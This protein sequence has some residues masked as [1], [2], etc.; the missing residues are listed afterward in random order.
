MKIKHPIGLAFLGLCLWLLFWPSEKDHLN[1][2]MAALCKKDGGVRIY[3]RVQL[4]P[5]MYNEWGSLKTPKTIKRGNEYISQ[6]A[7]IYES[8]TEKENIKNGDPFKG[9]G[10]LARHHTK[11]IRVTDKKILAEYISYSRVGGDRWF[12]G[13]PSAENCPINDGTSLLEKVFYK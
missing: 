7:D 4:S 3:E 12:A 1:K 10:S 11:V 2:Q 9:E 6:I 8:N 13:M 5:Q